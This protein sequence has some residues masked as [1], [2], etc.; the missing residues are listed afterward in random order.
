MRCSLILYSTRP[1]AFDATTRAEGLALAAQAVVA[2]RGP[3]TEEH[4][5]TAL[6]TRTDIG[7][8]HGVRM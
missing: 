2:A 6:T 1:H 7:Q 4:L 3:R 8:S 5:R